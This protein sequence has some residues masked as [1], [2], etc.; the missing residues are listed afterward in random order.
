MQFTTPERPLKVANRELATLD[1]V[2][3]NGE[4]RLKIDKGR[5]VTVSAERKHLD[6]GYVLT[7]HSS[8]GQTAD[9]VLVHVDTDHAGERLVNRRMA[10]V[11]L[12]RGAT[13]AHIY[14]NDPEQLVHALNRD[15]SRQSALRPE[16]VPQQAPTAVRGTTPSRLLEVT[17]STSL[18]RIFGLIP[19]LRAHLLD[20]TVTEIM[21]NIGGRAVFIE[22]NGS[23][24]APTSR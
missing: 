8:Q 12:S 4:L 19:Q 15:V 16:Q 18:A 2:G 13:D 22:R 9:R 7:S 11:S 23:S 3:P 24:S 10:Y 5:E 6:Y 17:M 21:V 20:P 14:T 1:S